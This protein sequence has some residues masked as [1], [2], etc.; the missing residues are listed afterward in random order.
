MVF[1]RVL[2]QSSIPYKVPET[3]FKA[4]SPYLGAFPEGELVQKG[5]KIS[6]GGEGEVIISFSKFPGPRELTTFPETP[7]QSLSRLLILD[8]HCHQLMP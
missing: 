6:P 7:H 5:I 1:Q 8:G 4:I 2:I 3:M